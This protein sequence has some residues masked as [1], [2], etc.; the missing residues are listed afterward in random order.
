MWKKK[1]E[2]SEYRNYLVSVIKNS[3]IK[4]ERIL[5][6]F[7]K[8]KREDFVKTNLSINEIYSDTAIPT[9]Y[10]DGKVSTSSQPSLMA[11]FIKEAK[12][13]ENK[14][15]LEIGT[16]TGYNAAILSEIV[17]E[18]GKVVSIESDETLWE[19][20][21]ENLSKYN[22]VVVINND[23]YY[24]YENE[25]PYD[26]ILTTVAIDGIPKTWSDQLKDGGRII[27]PIALREYFSDYTFLFEKKEGRLF[28]KFLIHTRF[29]RAQG[30]LGFKKGIVKREDFEP[31]WKE[32]INLD[33][34]I[35][36]FSLT[37]FNSDENY[38][39]SPDGEKGCLRGNYF[40]GI[41][42]KLHY[43]IKQ[44]QNCRFRI[45]E[46]LEFKSIL[47]WEFLNFIC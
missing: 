10:K 11:L 13:D 12:V 38:F 28:A 41:G 14:K 44:L 18:K 37:Y 22:N 24:G 46:N 8:V 43:I 30:K 5:K 15:V 39:L 16:G 3:G 33:K 6:A 47:F 7:S 29:L 42:E 26:A 23:G 32:K 40:V 34:R 25:A 20:S 4:N 2:M 9:Y 27:A 21:K 45:I 36:E 17:G 19:I 31:Q 35:L 1:E